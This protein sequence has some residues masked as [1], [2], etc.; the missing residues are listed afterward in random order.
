M[1][2]IVEHADEI[3]KL[4]KVKAQVSEIKSIM[5]ENIEKVDCLSHCPLHQILTFII[6]CKRRSLNEDLL[7]NLVL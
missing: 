7:F 3:E 2:Y 5:L 1:R 6:K 4:V